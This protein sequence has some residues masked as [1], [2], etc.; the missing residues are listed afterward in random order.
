MVVIKG[1]TERSATTVAVVLLS[2]IASMRH[3]HAKE[4]NHPVYQ[5]DVLDCRDFS[6]DLGHFAHLHSIDEKI[7][8]ELNV[9]DPCGAKKA[10]DLPMT[11]S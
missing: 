9:H 3:P 8:R 10:I 11:N 6:C 4:A 7:Q 2:P 1:Y 5:T